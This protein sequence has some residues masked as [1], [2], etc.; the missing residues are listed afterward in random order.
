MSCLLVGAEV[1]VLSFFDFVVH[2]FALPKPNMQVPA[3]AYRTFL[4]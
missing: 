3:N 4:T 1:T 2:P